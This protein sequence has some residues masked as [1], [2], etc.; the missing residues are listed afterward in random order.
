MDCMVG[1][2]DCEGFDACWGIV[3]R[4]SEMPNFIPCQMTFDA[5]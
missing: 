5:L 1:L 3:N 4:L 2:M